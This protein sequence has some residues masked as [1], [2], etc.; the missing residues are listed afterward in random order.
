MVGS[1]TGVRKHVDVGSPRL[2]KGNAR[3]A[4]QLGSEAGR[5]STHS[6]RYSRGKKLASV[7][8][9]GGRLESDPITMAAADATNITATGITPVPPTV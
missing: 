5:S 1:Q 6:C 8:S 3:P 9:D 2:P 4:R 7:S